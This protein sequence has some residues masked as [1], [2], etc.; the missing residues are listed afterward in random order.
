MPLI[1]RTETNQDFNQVRD[2]HVEAFGHRE[3]EANLVDRVR[4]SMFFIPEL[5]IVAELDK[6]IVGHLLI[7]KAV[8]VDHLVTHEVLLH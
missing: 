8:V 3:D 1:I 5:S 6:E 7:S 2:V 4:N